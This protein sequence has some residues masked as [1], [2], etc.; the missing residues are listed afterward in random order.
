MSWLKEQNR[1]ASAFLRGEFS[2]TFWMCAAAFCVLM[3]IG[4][5]LGLVKED[6]A[7]GFV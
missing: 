6:F 1:R 2:A 4:F 3:I 7:V 5:V